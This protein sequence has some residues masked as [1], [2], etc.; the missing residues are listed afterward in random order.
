M[1][2]ELDSDN[3]TSSS[4]SNDSEEEEYENDVEIPEIK[5]NQSESVLSEKKSLRTKKIGVKFHP[6]YNVQKKGCNI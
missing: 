2:M 5:A 6:L 3:I 4:E 1:D